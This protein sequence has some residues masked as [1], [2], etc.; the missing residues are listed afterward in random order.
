MRE[1][2][3]Y[4]ENGIL[5]LLIESLWGWG[6]LHISRD[7]CWQHPQYLRFF[8][9]RSG[10]VQE[11]E[12]SS[13]PDYSRNQQCKKQGVSSWWFFTMSWPLLLQIW[14]I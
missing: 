11:L 8:P 3:L 5:L 9:W 4:C 13:S 14:P 6:Y 7:G 2:L 1:G 10:R 12:A